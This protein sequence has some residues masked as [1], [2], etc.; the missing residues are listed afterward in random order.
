VKKMTVLVLPPG[1]HLSR[2]L[3]GHHR[4]VP[5]GVQQVALLLLLLL[6]HNM[7]SQHWLEG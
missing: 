2:I 3:L 1:C 6:L 7:Q 5:R 4:Q